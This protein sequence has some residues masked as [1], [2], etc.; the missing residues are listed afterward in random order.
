[1]SAVRAWFER[2]E[3][4]APGWY[5]ARSDRAIGAAVRMIYNSPAHPWTVAQLATEVGLSRAS[6]ACRFTDVVGEPPMRFLTNWRITLAADLLTEPGVTIGAVADQVGYSTPYA[7]SSLQKSPRH[8]PQTAPPGSGAVK[9]PAAAVPTSVRALLPVAATSAPNNRYGARMGIPGNEGDR[10][11]QRYQPVLNETTTVAVLFWRMRS[12]V[13]GS[14]GVGALQRAAWCDR[15][16]LPGGDG[17]PIV[18]RCVYV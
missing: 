4:P 16:G 18:P 3:T 6:L 11:L 9:I 12:I 1:M 2:P 8:Q 17:V 10:H 7:F 13:P 15:A 14:A 5:A